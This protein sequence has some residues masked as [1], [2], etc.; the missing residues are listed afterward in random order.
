M[1]GRRATDDLP[2]ASAERVKAFTDAVVAIAMT[3]LIL[4]LLDTVK[5]AAADGSSTLE[6][7]QNNFSPILVFLLSFVIIANFW[8]SHHRLFARVESVTEFL[9]WI[10]IAWMLT[11]VWLP[12]AT[13]ITGQMESDTL[14][15][16][17]Y[18]GSMTL[19]SVLLLCARLYLARHPALHDISPRDL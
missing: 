16:V 17:L 1:S 3:L 13:A 10:T 5:E 11:I 14:Q 4:P 7:L 15:R 19:T 6:W 12:V 2:F 9:L 18:I 8:T